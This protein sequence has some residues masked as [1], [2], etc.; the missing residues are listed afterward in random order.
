MARRL[1]HSLKARIGLRLA[2]LK[3]SVREHRTRGDAG[4]FV[5][6]G[7]QLIEK[8]DFLVRFWEL[9]ARH[10]TLGEPL[11]PKEQVELLSLMQL[12]THDAQLPDAGPV[13][14]SKHSIPAQV[15][16]DGAI[17]AVELRAVTAAG[18]LVASAASLPVDAHVIVRATDAISGVEYALPC[19]V[20][21][22]YGGN[23]CTMALAVDG[24]PTRSVFGAVS[25]P[26]IGINLGPTGT[27]VG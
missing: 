27:L 25:E 16:G 20:M 9:Q 6:E 10:K 12:V 24:I 5:R 22:V 19:K 13:A 17:K 26:P 8:L 14:R 21:W 2:F 1:H 4:D 23:P 15:I 11:S 18:L 3:L 7:A